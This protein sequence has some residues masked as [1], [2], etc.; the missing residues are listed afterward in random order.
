MDEIKDIRHTQE[1][2]KANATL[3]R[4]I[5]WAATEYEL[6]TNLGTKN[7][8]PFT[9]FSITKDFKLRPLSSSENPQYLS[10]VSTI[11]RPTLTNTT[12]WI[13]SNLL[14]LVDQSVSDPIISEKYKSWI[15][16]FFMWHHRKNMLTLMNLRQWYPK[17]Y[18]YLEQ[19]KNISDIWEKNIRQQL[20]KIL[21]NKFWEEAFDIISIDEEIKDENGNIITIPSQKSILSQKSIN[22][23]FTVFLNANKVWES[24]WKR[25]DQVF[26]D[27]DFPFITDNIMAN[28]DE[29]I[30][31]LLYLIDKSKKI[32]IEEDER[33]EKRNGQRKHLSMLIYYEHLQIIN[34]W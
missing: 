20:A 1:I 7:C 18:K 27:W 32:I 23:I 6:L 14:R 22:Y 8:A 5:K 3:E 17:C 30:K 10:N 16:D 26:H 11:K 19:T 28:E 29:Y 13:R 25:V 21:S 15:N 31:V 34:W 9:W 2:Q 24:W 12:Q 33:M 4:K